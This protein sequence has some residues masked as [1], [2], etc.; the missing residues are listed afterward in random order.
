MYVMQT[1]SEF[2]K[3]LHGKP[4]VVV[5]AFCPG[6]AKSDL[7]RG[8]KGVI[9]GVFRWVFG[10]LFLRRRSRGL[11]HLLVSYCWVRQ[12]MGGFSK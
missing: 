1:L 6:G 11:G 7:S 10:A 12:R 4:E 3:G 9:A 2:T 5:L 8:S